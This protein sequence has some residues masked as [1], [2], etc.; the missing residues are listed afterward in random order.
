[1]FR[2]IL[3]R[4]VNRSSPSKTCLNLLRSKKHLE[5]ENKLNELKIL[6]DLNKQLS[7][8]ALGN[9]LFSLWL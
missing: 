5:L 1:M 2:V 7:I 9:N 3:A 4:K 8:A 6:G